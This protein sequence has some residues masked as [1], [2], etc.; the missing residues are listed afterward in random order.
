MPIETA[1]EGL[2]GHL[3]RGAGKMTDPL[4][5]GF[6]VYSSDTWTPNVNLYE[7]PASYFVCVDLAGV[8][9]EKID[10]EV[11]NQR[12]TLKGSRLVPSPDFPDVPGESDPAQKRARVH[13]M[14]IDHGPFSRV[15]ELPPDANRDG[16]VANYRQGML[17]IEIPRT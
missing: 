15:V 7:T 4:Q 12:L 9:K 10:V 13:L 14:E 6:V 16:I 1:S 2:F 11:V 3:G 17:W 5:K 8:D